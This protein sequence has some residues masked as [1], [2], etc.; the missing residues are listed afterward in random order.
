[1]S[2]LGYTHPVWGH[3]FDH[4]V[5]EVAHDSIDRARIGTIRRAMHIQALVT[6]S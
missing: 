4:G 1:M 3:G 5:L 6:A 2:G